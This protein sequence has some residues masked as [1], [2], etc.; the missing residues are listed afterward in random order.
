MS[1][2][3]P[4]LLAGPQGVRVNE[5]FSLSKSGPGFDDEVAISGAEPSAA[6]AM[7][8]L[9]PTRRPPLHLQRPRDAAPNVS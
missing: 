1:Q 4:W 9:W 6:R 8:P 5:Q 2:L 3:R 7:V